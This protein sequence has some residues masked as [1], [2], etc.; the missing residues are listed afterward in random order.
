MKTVTFIFSLLLLSSV[1][2][3]S[4]ENSRRPASLEG[5]NCHEVVHLLVADDSSPSSAEQTIRQ[6]RREKLDQYRANKSLDLIDNQTK[7]KH[8]I[9]LEAELGGGSTAL[10][11]LAKDLETE[12]YLTARVKRFP[13]MRIDYVDKNRFFMEMGFRVPEVYYVSGDVIVTEY[14]EGI[15]LLELMN[16]DADNVLFSQ[17]GRSKE[18]I[19]SDYKLFEKETRDLFLERYPDWS[20][21]NS[22]EF[23]DL[24]S[25][26]IPANVLMNH[27]GEFILI[28]Y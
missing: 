9:N 5:A 24:R 25:D 21:Q 18:E 14:V 12:S 26:I 10:V 16:L 22:V 11:Y 13:N 23:R 3:I 1:F 20:T 19:I 4:K 27:E 2:F 28:D 17:L 7:A 6:F 15:T 8:R